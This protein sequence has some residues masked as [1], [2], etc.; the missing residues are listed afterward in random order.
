MPSGDDEGR[1]QQRGLDQAAHDHHAEQRLDERAPPV[2]ILNDAPETGDQRQREHCEGR[3]G[4]Q[5]QPPAD[6]IEQPPVGA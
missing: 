1:D 5:P 3:G 4:R 6:A 2:V